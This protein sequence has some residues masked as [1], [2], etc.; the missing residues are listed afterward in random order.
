[1]DPRLRTILYDMGV[2]AMTTDNAPSRSASSNLSRSSL[3]VL[4]E[5]WR[6]ESRDCMEWMES[7]TSVIEGRMASRTRS[8]VKKRAPSDSSRR[9]L[10]ICTSPPAIDP[11][12]IVTTSPSVIR[13]RDL[14]SRISSSVS[15]AAAQERHLSGVKYI[16]VPSPTSS[17]RSAATLRKMSALAPSRM[18][19]LASLS[20]FRR[21]PRA[22]R[23]VYADSAPSTMEPT[24]SGVKYRLEPSSMSSVVRG[25]VA[26]TDDAS[27]AA[28]LSVQYSDDV[29]STT[30]SDVFVPSQR[31]MEASVRRDLWP[32]SAT[33]SSVQPRT[34]SSAFAGVYVESPGTRSSTLVP[35]IICATTEASKN[36]CTEPSPRSSAVFCAK[37]RSQRAPCSSTDTNERSMT[38][39]TTVI[40]PT[41]DST[42]S[43]VKNWWVGASDR[44]SVV[45]AARS[46][47]V[48]TSHVSRRSEMDS[49]QTEVASS[50]IMSSAASLSQ[51]RRDPSTMSSVVID[52]A[53]SFSRAGEKKRWLSCSATIEVSRLISRDATD[54]VCAVA[55]DSVCAEA[56]LSASTTH[57]SVLS[58]VK[59]SGPSGCSA[60][61][62]VVGATLARERITHSNVSLCT[63]GSLPTAMASSVSP[64][65]IALTLSSTSGLTAF[66]ARSAVK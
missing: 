39:G 49:P 13:R 6:L 14:P 17:V 7:P 66:L 34:T 59:Y 27:A 46:R 32:P 5:N 22:T 12:T 26:E 56:T 58:A 21:S 8:S 41:T 45:S 43:A 48:A 18:V 38:S 15:A 35:R 44:D 65:L 54:S 57:A 1:M 60:T 11:C 33:S 53:C 63:K 25:M 24:R 23:V 40:A 9:W 31:S 4:E 47:V 51:K 61:S 3:S 10:P 52:P 29:P 42:R 37:E 19:W 50:T 16:R 20:S 55:T 30:S 36:L 62:L 2:T 28:L 64:S